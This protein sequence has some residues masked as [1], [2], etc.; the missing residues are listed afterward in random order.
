MEHEEYCDSLT[1]LLN[2]TSFQVA[3][4]HRLEGAL[5]DGSELALAMIDLDY[6]SYYNETYE[7][8]AGDELLVWLADLIRASISDGELACR[9]AGDEIA[10]LLV[11]KKHEVVARMEKLCTQ[12]AADDRPVTLSVG[13]AAFPSDA[14]SAKDW[15]RAADHALYSAKRGGRN[16]VVASKTYAERYARPL[17]GPDEGGSGVTAGRVPPPTGLSG[18]GA[19]RLPDR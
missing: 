19:E 12:M 9:F 3:I 2:H 18:G 10:L 15:L 8:L 16:Q 11:G 17:R 13:V 4:R 1:G 5:E 6:F 14:Q 7:Y